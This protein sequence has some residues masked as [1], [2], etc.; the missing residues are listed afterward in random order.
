MKEVRD[1][2]GDSTLDR[3]R[4][5]SESRQSGSLRRSSV[6]QSEVWERERETERSSRLECFSR[7]ENSRFDLQSL[8]NSSSVSF[9]ISGASTKTLESNTSAAAGNLWANFCSQASS[10]FLFLTSQLWDT[11]IME[12]AQNFDPNTSWKVWNIC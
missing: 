3:G 4:E 11:S 12:F 5:W 7:Q 9:S 1:S 2:T 6:L 8:Y 10:F